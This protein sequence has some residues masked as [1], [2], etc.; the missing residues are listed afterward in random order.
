[1]IKIWMKIDLVSDSINCNIV[2]L[3]CLENLWGMTNIVRFTFSVGD[4]TWAIY[5]Q[6]QA[7]KQDWWHYMQCLV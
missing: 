6:H 4:T 5:I 3:L 2:I 1:M 7:C